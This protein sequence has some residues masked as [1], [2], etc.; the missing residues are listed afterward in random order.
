MHAAGVC[1]GGMDELQDNID[2]GLF[3][4]T[5]GKYIAANAPT[6]ATAAAPTPPAPGAAVSS[7]SA[8]PAS[9]ARAVS[10]LGAVDREEL[11]HLASTMARRLAQ[12]TCH[13]M[14]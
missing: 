1:R 14:K 7:V 12:V 6:P 5:Y 2:S 4:D 11:A 10:S 8:P 3:H 9:V 13:F